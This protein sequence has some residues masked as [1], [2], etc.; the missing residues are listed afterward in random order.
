MKVLCGEET[1]VV[2]T[3]EEIDPQVTY[4][5]WRSLSARQIGGY[6]NE[7]FNFVKHLCLLKNVFY[8]VLNI[9]TKGC[10]VDAV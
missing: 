6:R 4:S 7:C 10:S 8:T 2:K 9:L 5:G 1:W 3:K